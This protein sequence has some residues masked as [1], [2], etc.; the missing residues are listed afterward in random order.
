MNSFRKLKTML[1]KKYYQT[2]LSTK[3][4]FHEIIYSLKTM[5]YL[6]KLT[7]ERQK[8]Q[9]E[10]KLL[11]DFQFPYYQYPEYNRAFL[12]YLIST[13]EPRDAAFNKS[14]F[15]MVLGPEGVGKTWFMKYNLK[16]LEAM[17]MNVKPLVRFS[18][19]SGKH[20][21]Y[22]IIIDCLLGSQM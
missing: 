9:K 10:I 17:E 15:L 3:D 4:S 13:K 14:N 8:V 2:I 16:T 22:L 19:I 18:I 5:P 21:F 6:E 12:K 7:D 11:K 20:H 1:I